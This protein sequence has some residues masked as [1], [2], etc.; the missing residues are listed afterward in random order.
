MV[1]LLATLYTHFLNIGPVSGAY[2]NE[3]LD[4]VDFGRKYAQQIIGF[5]ELVTIGVEQEDLVTNI[6]RIGEPTYVVGYFEKNMASTGGIPSMRLQIRKAGYQQT[7]SDEWMYNCV[8]PS[9]I[10][11]PSRELLQ[12]SLFLRFAFFPEPDS[13]HFESHLEYIPYYNVALWLSTLPVGVYELSLTMGLRTEMARGQFIVQINPGDNAKAKSY[14]DKLFS[15]KL[16]ST[17]FPLPSCQNKA[18]AIPNV[19]E[20]SRF[21][22]LV[23]VDYMATGEELEVQISKKEK[24]KYILAK[25]VGIFEVEGKYELVNLEFRKEL[26]TN[27]YEYTGPGPKPMDLILRCNDEDVIFPKIHRNGYEIP[28][29]NIYYCQY[30]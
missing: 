10:R 9:Y 17:K 26:G 5:K 4:S 1:L 22:K 28:K 29:E 20:L 15:R 27:Y 3:S 25:G 2:A 23:K 19:Q 7:L 30:W 24:V 11:A 16:N 13:L 21:G 12:D 8:Q 18:G 6:I 14:L